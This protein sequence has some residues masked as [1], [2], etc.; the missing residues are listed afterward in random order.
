MGTDSA[1]SAKETAKEDA[2]EA[3]RTAEQGARKAADNPALEWLGHGGWIVKGLI[4]LAAAR[5]MR[6]PGASR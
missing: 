2:R 1:V 4:C 5:W 6:M 3:G